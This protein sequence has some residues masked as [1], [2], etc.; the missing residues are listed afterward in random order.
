MEKLLGGVSEMS[1]IVDCTSLYA[2]VNC[3]GCVDI[4]AV[5]SG[6]VLQVD[7]SLGCKILLILQ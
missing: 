4:C 2:E 3:V 1:I 6:Q 5:V 7:C